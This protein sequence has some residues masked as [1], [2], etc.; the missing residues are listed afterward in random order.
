MHSDDDEKGYY[1]GPDSRHSQIKKKKYFTETSPRNNKNTRK[2][3]SL[4]LLAKDNKHKDS[5]IPST[6]LQQAQ[7]KEG[8]SKTM[9]TNPTE[10]HTTL[11]YILGE[12]TGKREQFIAV[13][14]LEKLNNTTQD[15]ETKHIIEKIIKKYMINYYNEKKEAY[16]ISSQR[17]AQKARKKTNE[18][19]KLKSL[20]KAQRKIEKA[21]QYLELKMKRVEQD[22]HECQDFKE[23][24]AT[25]V[26][27]TKEMEQIPAYANYQAMIK[28]AKTMETQAQQHLKFADFIKENRI[29]ANAIESTEY[30]TSSKRKKEK[31]T[32]T[33][34]AGLRYMLGRKKEN[35]VKAEKKTRT[36]S[37]ILTEGMKS[38]SR[39][40]SKETQAQ[41]LMKA[42]D[43]LIGSAESILASCDYN[44][45]KSTR[46][47]WLNEIIETVSDIEEEKIVVAPKSNK[48][49]A[50]IQKLE[51][52]IQEIQNVLDE[53]SSSSESP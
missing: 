52:E 53:K 8:S 38:D 48:K 19:G 47:Q 51:K 24:N 16:C 42:Q 22:Y 30:T 20:K 29:K 37:G 10:I 32:K 35:L 25:I 23:I 33:V 13:T 6:M 17:C 43:L 46:L 11:L 50:I 5:I 18:I 28:K 49:D 39:E 2:R 15:E 40:Q 26:C 27:L 36:F 3:R 44:N 31:K 12:R 41:L 34:T 9:Q 7:Q 14:L 4:S 45:P 1:S 21:L